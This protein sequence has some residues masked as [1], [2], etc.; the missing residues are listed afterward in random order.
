MSFKPAIIANNIYTNFWF[1]VFGYVGLVLVDI[2]LKAVFGV[3]VTIAMLPVFMFLAYFLLMQPAVLCAIFFISAVDE[4]SV[5]GGWNS[6]KVWITKQVPATVYLVM[7]IPL[8]ITFLPVE[9]YLG[10]AVLGLVV[11]WM[12]EMASIRMDAHIGLFILRPIYWIIF[13]YLALAGLYGSHFGQKFVNESPMAQKVLEIYNPFEDTKGQLI[14][15]NANAEMRKTR[16]TVFADCYAAA[17]TEAKKNGPLTDQA[18]VDRIE[19]QCKVKAGYEKVYVPPVATPA[20]IAQK[21]EDRRGNASVKQSVSA[22][23]QKE[24]APSTLHDPINDAPKM[25]HQQEAEYEV[26]FRATRSKYYVLENNIRIC[27]TQTCATGKIDALLSLADSYTEYAK[28]VPK[29]VDDD[30]RGARASVRTREMKDDYILLATLR[31]QYNAAQDY[32]LRQGIWANIK[33]L[34]DRLREW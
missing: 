2:G 14:R 34:D 12:I 27:Q 19:H 16:D 26:K 3:G 29:F 31:E 13:G 6:T 23:P 10:Y 24:V 11:Y 15:D 7:L 17:I 9:K 18:I 32:R 33:D 8:T 5:R 30:G 21:Q 4:W 22:V 1:V 28:H 25:T 20:P